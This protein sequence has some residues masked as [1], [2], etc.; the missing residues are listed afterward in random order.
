MPNLPS[1]RPLRGKARTTGQTVDDHREQEPL[2]DPVQPPLTLAAPAVLLGLDRHLRVGGAG[3]AAGGLP[4]VVF[5]VAREPR[6][7]AQVGP[8][9]VSVP[10][11]PDADQ[12]AHG[13]SSE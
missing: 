11:P 8:A 3:G 2:H 13:A 7:A 5:E 12:I 4:A 1:R 6:P 9:P 10:L